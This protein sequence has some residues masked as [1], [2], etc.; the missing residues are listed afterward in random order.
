[1]NL[2]GAIFSVLSVTF[3]GIYLLPSIIIFE[4]R[5]LQAIAFSIGD[6]GN[7]LRPIRNIV[8]ANLDSKLAQR[9]C[10]VAGNPIAGLDRADALRRA[11]VI[12]VARVERVECRSELDQPRDVE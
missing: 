11:G 8:C 1:M 3:Q 4:G 9:R 7:T 2:S 5:Y 10:R 12:K 6:G